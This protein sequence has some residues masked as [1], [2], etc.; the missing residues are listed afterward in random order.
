PQVATESI[1][2]RIS[3]GLGRTPIHIFLA[4]VALIWLAPKIGLL[5]TSFRP[6]SDIQATGW[7]EILSTLRLTLVNSTDVLN[8]QGMAPA[9]LNSVI[10]SVPST[11]IPLTLC[12]LAAYGFS[13][14]KFPYKDSLF[15]IVVALMMVSV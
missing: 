7:W 15:L 4:I 1:T 8:A 3:R 13:W 6:R 10:I 2:A 9:F 12:S 11:L 5:V 14:L